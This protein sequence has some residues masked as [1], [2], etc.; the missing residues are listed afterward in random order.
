[1]PGCRRWRQGSLQPDRRGSFES[2]FVLFGGDRPIP[3]QRIEFIFVT[4]ISFC[5]WI[6]E[7]RSAQARSNQPVRSLPMSGHI[8]RRSAPGH[9]RHSLQFAHADLKTPLSTFN[10][11]LAELHE[12]FAGEPAA[13]RSRGHQFSG[14]RGVPPAAMWRA[15]PRR[16]GKRIVR[17]IRS[18][19]RIRKCRR[20]K[21]KP[22][23]GASRTGRAAGAPRRRRR[24]ADLPGCVRG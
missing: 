5:R 16:G 4:V 13:L 14:T 3:R 1:M 6:G 2:P 7:L 12:R 23:R 11:Q 19:A 15:A 22:P 24:P 21:Y 20:S 17:R 18:R 10:P 8:G 9:V